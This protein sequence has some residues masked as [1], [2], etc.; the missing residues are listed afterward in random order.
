FKFFYDFVDTVEIRGKNR[1][2]DFDADMPGIDP[3][4]ACQPEQP[5]G[6]I[7]IQQ[8][9]DG[10]VDRYAYIIVSKLHE[11]VQETECPDDHF[12]ADRKYKFRLFS[13]RYE[14]Q[15]RYDPEL[16]RLQPAQHFKITDR[17]CPEI[18]YRLVQQPQVI[19]LRVPGRYGAQDLHYIPFA[20]DKCFQF[21][22]VEAG[23]EVFLKEAYIPFRRDQEPS[24]DGF[25]VSLVIAVSDLEYPDASAYPLR[26]QQG[27][28]GLHDL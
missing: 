14:L 5:A 12:F 1:F 13:G 9:Y 17:I 11:P 28:Q 2:G 23:F 21:F 3:H 16:L 15:R 22:I 20:V 18:H 6:E 24:H 8:L 25:D 19:I 4:V 26:H 27:S 7:R 10:N